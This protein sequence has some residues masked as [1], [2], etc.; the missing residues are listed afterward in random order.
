MNQADLIN[1]T[2]MHMARQGKPAFSGYTYDTTGTVK[3]GL[4]CSY[5]GPGGTKCAV[6]FWI[7]DDKYNKNLEGQNA[8]GVEHVL[9]EELQEHMDLLQILQS[10][11]HDNMENW[12]SPDNMLSVMREVAEFREVTLDPAIEPTLRANWKGLN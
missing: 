4:V 3:T 7:P 8:L 11:V 1:Q 9:P 12:E 6:G 5:R 2:F 10:N